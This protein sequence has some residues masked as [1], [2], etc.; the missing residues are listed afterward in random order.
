MMMVL[1]LINYVVNDVNDFS[2][3]FYLINLVIT[4]ID[5]TVTLLTAKNSYS[6]TRSYLFHFDLQKKIFLK[7]S[8]L[9]LREIFGINSIGH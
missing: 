2:L 9:R 1:L 4:K 5:F 7:F 3:R 8:F 6:K